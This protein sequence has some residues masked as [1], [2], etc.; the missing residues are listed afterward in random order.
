[1]DSLRAKVEKMLTRIRAFRSRL[2]SRV[3][4]Q[5]QSCKVEGFLLFRFVFFSCYTTKGLH[6]YEY[7]R[8]TRYHT[9]VS[10]Y[11]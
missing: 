8:L 4:V 3:C 6:V 5:I 1:M 7:A 10:T 2:V 11:E 9:I